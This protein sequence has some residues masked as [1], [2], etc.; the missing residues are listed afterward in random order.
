[1][2]VAGSEASFRAEMVCPALVK[3]TTAEGAA[4]TPPE[5]ICGISG[6]LA[7]TTPAAMQNILPNLF[8]VIQSPNFFDGCG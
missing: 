3:S 4:T 2:Q 5:L 8:R 1:V 6:R 7:P